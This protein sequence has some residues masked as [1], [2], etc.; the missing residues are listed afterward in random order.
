MWAVTLPIQKKVLCTTGN[1]NI[2][3]AEIFCSVHNYKM[4]HFLDAK[5]S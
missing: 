1:V 5:L 4:L 3:P 2:H